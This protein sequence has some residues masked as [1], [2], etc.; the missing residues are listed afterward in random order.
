MHARHAWHRQGENEQSRERELA[1]VRLEHVD[2]AQL[3]P[4]VQRGYG[5]RH[6]GEEHRYRT[7]Q[8]TSNPAGGDVWQDENDNAGKADQ[9]TRI[10]DW[11]W[12]LGGDDPV[13]EKRVPQ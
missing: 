4:L 13:D 3:A 9:D 2:A 1:E 6:R 10:V 12:A 8:V 7:D 11:A 5:V